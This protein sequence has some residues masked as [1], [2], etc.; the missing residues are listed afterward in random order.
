M[1][2]IPPQ[3]F[4]HAKKLKRETA[5]RCKPSSPSSNFQPILEIR[6]QRTSNAL[7]ALTVPILE[8]IHPH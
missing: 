4:Y 5:R 8:L 6:V 1:G 2:S 7:L 3:L